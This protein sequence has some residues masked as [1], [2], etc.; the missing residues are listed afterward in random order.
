MK[1]T[2]LAAAL[3]RQLGRAACR[4]AATAGAAILAGGMMFSGTAEAQLFS[5]DFDGLALGPFVSGT[6]SG[7]DGTDWTNV[8]PAGWTRDNGSTPAA[9]PAEFFGFTFLDKNSWVA[10]AA[11]QDRT[12]FTKGTGTVMVADADEYDDS[13]DIDPDQFNVLIRTPT[14][15]TAGIAAN[16]LRLNFD[17][18]FRP[19][20]GMTGL[21]DV[22][23]DGGTNFS[24]VLTLDTAS[25]PGGAS[26]LARADES[27]S[28][29]LNNPGNG[30]GLVVRFQMANAGNDWWWAVDNI[31]VLQIP[32]PATA[33][34][35]GVVAAGIGLAAARRRR[36]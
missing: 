18:S 14:I 3:S 17:S 27:V 4:S 25:T 30:G 9:G 10:T 31:S 12:S 28:L 6:E 23:F 2:N 16:N 7:G 21:V 8:V 19:Y 29:L 13:G 11:D 35:M 22:S 5:E 15:S 36:D 20:D 32:E 33:T 1:V 24:N 34:L 26:S